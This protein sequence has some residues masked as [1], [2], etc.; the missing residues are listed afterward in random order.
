VKL[1]FDDV[2]ASIY[3]YVISVICSAV[4]FGF[5]PYG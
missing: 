2:L 3:S 4:T 5:I 1:G